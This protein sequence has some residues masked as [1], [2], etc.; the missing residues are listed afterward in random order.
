MIPSNFE[1]VSI[2]VPKVAGSSF[3]YSLRVKYGYKH[4]LRFLCK[5]TGFYQ[6]IVRLDVDDDG[7][8]NI[9]GRKSLPDRIPKRVK[10]I[11]GHFSYQYYKDNFRNKD[12]TKLVTW[13]REPLERLMSNYLY[14][15]KIINE[16]I[17]YEHTRKFAYPLMEKNFMEFAREEN[18]QNLMSKYIGDNCL[19]DYAFVGVQ[20]RYD[21]E[22]ERFSKVL[23]WNN[24]EKYYQ[25]KTNAKPVQLTQSELEEIKSYNRKDYQLYN[26]AVE[27]S[28][29]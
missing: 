3:W 28:S 21:S 29:K 14:F 1:L 19:S 18:N 27:L 26:Y 11:H 24:F 22:V 9:N 2:H 7:T 15:R 4:P 5:K 12:S 25:N 13:V 10:V 23:G 8:V 16:S 20:E 17:K 6:P